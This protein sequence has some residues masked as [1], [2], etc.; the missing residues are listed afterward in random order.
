M[1]TP[2]AQMS[3]RM[4]WKAPALIISGEKNAGV[5][6]DFSSE[7]S[8]CPECNLSPSSATLHAWATPRS[9]ILTVRRGSLT[10]PKAERAPHGITPHRGRGSAN[11]RFSGL[12]SRWMM[13]R[14]WRWE[15]PLSRSCTTGRAARSVRYAFP[16]KF[17]A[18]ITSPPCKSSMAR[19]I[20]PP[21]VSKMTSKSF[22]QFGWS[23]FFITAISLVTAFTSPVPPPGTG[24]AGGLPSFF[25]LDL[26][27]S[28]RLIATLSPCSSVAL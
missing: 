1:V 4:P 10:I 13:P 22:T 2:T 27:R 11:T 15:R 23:I 3:A 25:G 7:S 8:T 18:C 9:M 5:P 14:L 20:R 16:P 19:N 6:S 12:M 24:L 28:M 26:L 17:D 21:R